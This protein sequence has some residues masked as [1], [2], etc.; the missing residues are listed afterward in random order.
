LKFLNKLKMEWKKVEGLLKVEEVAGGGTTTTE[1]CNE[2]ITLWRKDSDLQPC[3][4]SFPFCIPLP[5]TFSD[6]HGSWVRDS[7]LISSRS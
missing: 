6:E 3:P 5:T 2:T 4:S 1:L 7:P